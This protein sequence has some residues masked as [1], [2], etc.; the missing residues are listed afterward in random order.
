MRNPSLHMGHPACWICS[1]ELSL[2][3]GVGLLQTICH[4]RSTSTLQAATHK[5]QSNACSVACITLVAQEAI[6]SDPRN[7]LARFEKASTLAAVGDVEGALAELQALTHVAPGEA[8][9]YFMV[10][11][12]TYSS[13]AMSPSH[14]WRRVCPRIHASVSV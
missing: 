6:A 5:C 8:S 14:A 12:S 4:L 11:H 13:T 1:A 2:M 7:P 10:R 3:H 9:V